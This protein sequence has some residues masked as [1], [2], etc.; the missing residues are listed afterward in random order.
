MR[1]PTRQLRRHRRLRAETL[2]SRTMLSSVA[3]LPLSIV[4]LDQPASS[5]LPPDPCIQFSPQPLVTAATIGTPIHWQGSFTERLQ[6]S[7][8]TAA[9]APTAWLVDVVYNLNEKPSP[10]PVPLV[11]VKGG[12]DFYLSGTA[13]ETLTPLGPSGN[14][15]ASAQSWVSKDSIQSQVIVLP[16]PLMNPVANSF[17]FSTDTTTTQT[18]TRLAATTA[19]PSWIANTTTLAT[20]GITEPSLESGTFSLNE[21]INQTLSPFSAPILIPDWTI[22]AKFVGSGTFQKT[23]PPTGTTLPSDTLAFTGALTGTITLPSG[24]LTQLLNSQ[25]KASV[26]YSPT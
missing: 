11:I 21:Q 9:S 3:A 22:S 12:Y 7:S 19:I 4:L 24:S 8:P 25:V 6:D 20:G 16:S 26:V 5:A 14:P 10:I 23:L 1:K 2:E 13:T 17:T 15:I 18:M